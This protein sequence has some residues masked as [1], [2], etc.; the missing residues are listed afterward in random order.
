MQ[1]C[2]QTGCPTLVRRGRCS[3][4]ARPQYA[5]GARGSSSAQGYGG[6]HRRWRAAVLA[7]DPQCVRCGATSMVADHRTPLRQ[8]GD[9]SLE[10]GQ[11]LCDRC[12][13]RKRASEDK[14]WRS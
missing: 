2:A 4:H 11:G 10:N 9:W 1:P 8:G 7:R 3:K 6:P 14:A 13:N 5:P 12:H